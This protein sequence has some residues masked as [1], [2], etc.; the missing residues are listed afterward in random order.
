[1]TAL[2]NTNITIQ[3]HAS[4]VPAP[5]VTWSKDGKVVNSKG[6][7]TVKDDGLLLINGAAHEDSTRYTCTVDNAAGTDS[8]SSTVRIV[9]KIS[10]MV[11]LAYVVLRGRY[12]KINLVLF[13]MITCLRL[14]PY[15]SFYGPCTC[16]RRV[17]LQNVLLKYSA[18]E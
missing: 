14:I 3:C 5:T 8:A 12:Y 16:N 17:C 9:G 7:Y 18:D 13:V 11:F 4:G 10:S 15:L 1:M 6:S 2:T